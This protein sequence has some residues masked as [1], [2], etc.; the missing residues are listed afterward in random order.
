MDT[1]YFNA[2]DFN[3]DGI[4]T[5]ADVKKY[6]EVTGRRY[7]ESDAYFREMDEDS[8]GKVGTQSFTTS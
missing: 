4:L 7:Q 5:E 8:D 1:R 2:W 6:S 3:H